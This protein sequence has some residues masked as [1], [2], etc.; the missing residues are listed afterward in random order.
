MGE[1]RRKKE[2]KPPIRPTE[3][4]DPIPLPNDQSISDKQ[5]VFCKALVDDVL[6]DESCLS[7]SKPVDEL[8]DRDVLGDYFEKIQRPMDV[9][10]VAK[11]VV[12]STYVQKG[13]DLFNPNAFREECRLVF[14]NAILYNGK[15]SELGRL[16]TRFLHYIDAELAKIPVP[17]KE[18]LPA[19]DLD[20]QESANRNTKRSSPTVSSTKR[21]FDATEKK[22]SSGINDDNDG[23]NDG[24]GDDNDGDRAQDDNSNDHVDGQKS[25]RTL[26]SKF[27]KSERSV[28]KEGDDFQT[29]TNNAKSSRRSRDDTNKMKID[30][31]VDERGGASNNGHGEPTSEKSG[32]HE[33]YKDGDQKDAMPDRRET[34]DDGDSDAKEAALERAEREKLEREIATLVKQRSRAHARIAEF[35]LEKNLPLTHDENSRLRDEVEALPWEK[36]QKVVQILRKYVDEAVKDSDESDPEFVTLEFSTVEPRLLREIEALIRPDPRLEKEKNI[37]ESAQRDIE[38]ARRKLK[39]LNDGVPSDRKK[40]RSKKS[41]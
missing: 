37:I 11:R 35:E 20:E 10:T 41:R 26:D 32:P 40:K 36:S 1:A 24:D 6:K 28:S 30:E 7:F 21:S 31:K 17:V 9:G 19:T 34:N 4:L 33:D 13:T 25:E 22:S 14:L 12:S 3:N 15:T 16:A 29:A 39:R 18:A 23:G 2:R 8:W 38:S 27:K 5:K